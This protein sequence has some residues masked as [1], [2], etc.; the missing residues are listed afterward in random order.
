MV[1]APLFLFA[2]ASLYPYNMHAMKYK[3]QPFLLLR[4][5]AQTHKCLRAAR[6]ARQTMDVSSPLPLR[7]AAKETEKALIKRVICLQA[8]YFSSP[9]LA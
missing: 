2:G 5:L 8:K 6:R 4:E 1:P 7:R 9:V 3:T